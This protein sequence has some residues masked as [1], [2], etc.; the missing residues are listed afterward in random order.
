MTTLSLLREKNTGD[1][2]GSGLRPAE[3]WLWTRHIISLGL[4]DYLKAVSTATVLTVGCP[5]ATQDA[6]L[7]ALFDKLDGV[8][9][10]NLNSSIHESNTTMLGIHSQDTQ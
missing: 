4:S 5:L 8:M 1:D 7:G 2:L 3:D 6:R 10:T 9:D